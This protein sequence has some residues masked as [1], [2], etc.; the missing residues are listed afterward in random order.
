[1]NTRT[2]YG[3]VVTK[4]TFKAESRLVSVDL[5]RRPVKENDLEEAFLSC[6]RL[7]TLRN[8]V[9]SIENLDNTFEGCTSLLN[10]P[11]IPSACTSMKG[12]FKNCIAFNQEI[13]I[14]SNVESVEECFEGCRKLTIQPKF[15]NKTLITSLKSTFKNTSLTDISDI[16]TSVQNFEDTFYGCRNLIDSSGITFENAINL[17][18]TF[19]N[20][21][22]LSTILRTI[23]STVTNLHQTF[24]NCS[25]IDGIIDIQSSNITDATDCF[26]VP[27]K[28]VKDRNV[29]L[30]IPSETY[31]S[32]ITAGYSQETRQHGVLLIPK[33]HTM[34]N[35]EIKSGDK[36]IENIKDAVV[37]ITYNGHTQR[38]RNTLDTHED[39]T[40]I[41]GCKE[42]VFYAIIPFNMTYT[43]SVTGLGED[44]FVDYSEQMST[45]N[46]YIETKNIN[47]TRKSST[48]KLTVQPEHSIG[49]IYIN[50]SEEPVSQGEGEITYTHL[51]GEILLVRYRGENSA[52]LPDEKVIAWDT[53]SNL[54]VSLNLDRPSYTPGQ[55]LYESNTGGQTG[56]LNLYKN[57]IYEITCVGG[58]GGSS[59]GAGGAGAMWKAN[60]HVSE[61]T[62][63]NMLT[64]N[65]GDPAD[66]Y[67]RNH[68]G[69]FGGNSTISGNKISIVGTG[70]NPGAPSRGYHCSC[71]L[72]AYND[73]HSK[74][75]AP[76]INLGLAREVLFS[77]N[78]QQRRE[79]YINGT[80]YG[81][82][83]S[84]GHDGKG[85]G[86]RGYPGYIRISYYGIETE[87]DIGI[88]VILESDTGTKFFEASLYRIK[89]AGGGGGSLCFKGPTENIYYKATG[90]SGSQF[91]IT[92]Y[93]PAGDYSW[94]IGQ[95]GTSINVPGE[96]TDGGD[97]TLSFGDT[98]IIAYGG[99]K[100]NVINGEYF[101]GEGGSM[102]TVSGTTVYEMLSNKAG[103]AG[104][105]DISSSNNLAGGESVYENYGTG[106]EVKNAIAKNGSKGFLEIIKITQ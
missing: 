47:L 93:L 25:K 14:P 19:Y 45:T 27:N 97:T 17:K 33:N 71:G 105:Q 94:N 68:C 3:T 4:N 6:I 88:P 100:G 90:G 50:G 77:N 42:N 32:F 80:N 37:T 8:G 46:E 51:T 39:H 9:N 60:V 59:Y 16:P 21:V 106:G 81:A 10:V 101:G 104:S 96:N 83:A 1:M 30:P 65:A 48:F 13:S 62:V 69:K 7:E 36:E 78:Y 12:T 31:N 43:L 18:N 28:T 38:C 29:W 53:N 66:G 49:K 76:T 41:S 54:E 89:A 87:T 58:G 75:N 102:C 56:S 84:G 98:Q 26:Y 20:C 57:Y 72:G 82:G 79:S 92:V 91:E 22:N 11:E 74:S 63:I 2:T 85:E 23:P 99:K 52:L 35:F 64:G 34:V 15:K 103:N 55:V 95:G 24:Y 5:N 61:N 44:I 67:C 40:C 73:R 70:G 86:G